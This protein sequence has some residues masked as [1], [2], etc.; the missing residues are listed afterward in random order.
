MLPS[1]DHIVFRNSAFF[2]QKEAPTSLPSPSVVRAAGSSLPVG[3]KHSRPGPFTAAFKSINLV[4]KY[5]RTVTTSEGKCLWAIRSQLGDRCPVPEVYGWC[6]DGD[7]VFIY[8]ELIRGDTLSSRWTGL[9]TQEK[10]GISAQ[11]K[12][13]VGALRQFKLGPGDAA[14]SMLYSDISACVSES[15]YAIIH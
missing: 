8:M 15:Y 13:M 4:V 7:E 14:I 3:S 5:G 9:S 2:A 1:A 10:K 12:Q 11:L 6:C